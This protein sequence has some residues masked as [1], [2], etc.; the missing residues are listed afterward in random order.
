MI[1]NG[2]IPTV[3]GCGAARLYIKGDR[4]RESQRSAIPP[5]FEGVGVYRTQKKEKHSLPI[6]YLHKSTI[7]APEQIFLSYLCVKELFCA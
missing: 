6:P 4:P 7:L 3:A 2:Q 5:A 1:F